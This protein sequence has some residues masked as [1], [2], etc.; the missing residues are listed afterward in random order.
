MA[1]IFPLRIK[2]FDTVVLN[3]FDLGY[4][5]GLLLY[6]FV[7]LVGLV[8]HLTQ[9]EWRGR[10]YPQIVLILSFALLKAIHTVSLLRCSYFRIFMNEF[11]EERTTIVVRNQFHPTQ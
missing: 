9:M 5:Q 8:V 2:G 1:S 4:T 7:T 10:S 3:C 6:S 11:E